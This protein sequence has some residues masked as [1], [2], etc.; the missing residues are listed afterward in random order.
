MPGE[1]AALVGVNGAGKTTLVKIIVGELVP[2]AGTVDKPALIGYVPQTITTERLTILHGTVGE[3]MFEG[4][5]LN[6][7]SERLN[8]ALVSL[9]NQTSDATHM[10]KAMNE[11]AEIQ[12]EFSRRGGYEAESEIESILRGVGVPVDL[13]RPVLTLS[14]GEKTRLAFARMIFANSDLLILDE[15]T[16][17][18]DYQYY[19]WLGSYLSQ[20]KKTILVVSHH[21]EFINP[22]TKRIIEIE[23]LTGRAREYRGIYQSYLKQSKVNEGT[24]ER[25]IAD[26]DKE[27][28]RLMESARRLQFA[29]PNKAKAAQNMFGRVARLQKK[30]QDLSDALP[31][32]EKKLRF[33][34]H[35]SRR[36]GQVV[37]KTNDLCKSFTGLR[38]SAINFEIYRGERVVVL[39][40]NGSGKTTLVRLL[41]GL[42]KPDSG[43]VEVDFNV[44]LGYYA[45]E[46]ENLS[47][48]KTVLEEIQAANC[49]P[50]VNPRDILGRF[51]FPQH[52]V[53]QTVET[54]SLGEKS[55]LSLCK[56]IVGGNNLLILDEPTNYLDIDSRDAVGDALED[57]E[58]TLIFV[59]HDKE[60]IRH[61][62]PDRAIVMPSGDIQ[63]FRE[64]LL[65][66]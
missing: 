12:E 28:A 14:G 64:E 36:S 10:G 50:Q 54:L 66:E 60:L 32:H 2:T 52:K 22:F 3:F 53:F 44:D 29:G 41:I 4:R 46:H 17:H 63:I 45:Q 51:L 25:Q 35:T 42:I 26:L 19:S 34:F 15:P 24:I 30:R 9:G 58:G 39:G 31:K 38:L 56:L 20:S 40:P 55:R 18:I 16:N 61:I 49:Q 27:I 21:P 6:E 65:S 8:R 7:L 1:K 11:Y 5:G 57:Y 59:S 48:C 33:T 43:S 13:D 37:A 47:Q 62:H 23:K